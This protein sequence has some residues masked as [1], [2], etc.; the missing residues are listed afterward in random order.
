MTLPAKDLFQDIKILLHNARNQVVRA[1]NTTMVHT[2]FEIG[3][4]IVEHE[5]KGNVKAEYGAETLKKLSVQLTKEFRKGFSEDNLGR[6]KNFY[7]TYSKSISATL[8]R[9]LEN[10]A[11]VE[12]QNSEAQ[13]PHFRLSWSHY[14]K[15][16]RISNI[17]ERQFYEYEAIQN[18]WSLSE[19][20]RQFDSALYERI[21]LSRD[22]KGVLADNLEKYYAPQKPE[23]VVKDPYILEFLGLKEEHRYSESEL[24]QAIIDKIEHFLL[25]LGKGF[26]FVGRQQ[27]FTFSEKHFFVDLVFYNR[28]LRCFVVIDL[29]IG[30]LTHQDLGQIQMYVNYYDR[31]VKTE[32]ENPTIGIVLCK[33]KESSLV[34]IT[35]PKDNTQI[36]ASQYQLYLPTKAELQMQI[37][38]ATQYFT[39]KE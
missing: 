36:F 2:Y 38:Q 18:N 6:M 25:E 19:F 13:E 9:K 30:D 28:L 7:L 1:V 20:Q 39:E 8:S 5:Q 10:G 4:L 24:E 11:Q 33:N 3:R 31:F 34:E 26:A 21:V 12:V 22:K 23:D 35:L 14:L 37:N 17:P 29:K 27:R 15:L 16:M 32:D